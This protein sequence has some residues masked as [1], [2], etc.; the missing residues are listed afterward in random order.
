[1]TKLTWKKLTRAGV[2]STMSG[3]FQLSLPYLLPSAR[4]SNTTMAPPRP[5]LPAGVPGGC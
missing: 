5:L 1:M 2:C 4:M 3:S